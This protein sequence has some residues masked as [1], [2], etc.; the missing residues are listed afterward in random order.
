MTLIPVEYHGV[1]TT[2]PEH[3]SCVLLRWAE[4]NRILPIWMSPLSAAELEARDEG[5]IPRRPGTPDLMAEMST[6]L[7]SGVTAVNIIS[8]FE[9]VFIASLVFNDGEEIDARPS[10]AIKLARAL[11][12]D[13]HVEEDVLTQ[14]SFF[15]SDDVLEEYFGLRFSPAEESDGDDEVSAS[16]DAQADADFE[17]MMR[18]LGMDES[19]FLETG[20]E[21]DTD[22]T[23]GDNE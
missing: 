20:G 22:V 16:G 1:H 14:A 8:H 21:D 12:I 11:E 7:T 9:G 3:F 15:I 2:G 23:K 17:E 10:D 6:R 5:F 18:S 13:I 4:Q 19:D